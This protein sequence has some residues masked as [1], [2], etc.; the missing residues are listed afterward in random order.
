MKT[1]LTPLEIEAMLDRLEADWIAEALT[2]S[3][4]GEAPA[5]PDSPS[6]V[7]QRVARI[8]EAI[9]TTRCWP[10]ALTYLD[11]EILIDCVDG[12]TWQCRGRGTPETSK[13]VAVLERLAKKMIAAGIANRINVPVS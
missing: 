8:V 4:P 9:K 10:D 11:R 3:Y 1:K 13:A 5:V 6:E 12:S 2:D 7:E